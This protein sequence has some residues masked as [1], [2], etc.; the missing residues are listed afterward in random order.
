MNEVK[1]TVF[2]EVPDFDP[3]TLV[4]SAD[5]KLI[6]LKFCSCPN[7][8]KRRFSEFLTAHPQIYDDVKSAAQR[9]AKNGYRNLDVREILDAMRITARGQTVASEYLKV[10]PHD[11]ELDKRERGYLIRKLIMDD[12][13]L[14]DLFELEP[15]KCK[16]NCGYPEEVAP[17]EEPA[18]SLAGF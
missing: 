11:F 4:L 7:K 13:N 17:A 5:D 9:I 12:A 10:Y 6:D 1:G 2:K 16:A 18:E 3:R 14:A 15:I 8:Y